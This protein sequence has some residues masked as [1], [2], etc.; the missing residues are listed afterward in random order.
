[1]PPN[2]TGRGKYSKIIREL[3]ETIDAMISVFEKIL[4]EKDAEIAK[5]KGRI[6]AASAT[7]N[8]VGEIEHGQG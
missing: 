6:D 4:A 5:L 3:H 8:R 7:N 1:M 2:S